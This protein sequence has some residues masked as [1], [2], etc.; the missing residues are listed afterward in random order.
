[1]ERICH[2]I[3]LGIGFLISLPHFEFSFFFCEAPGSW[4]LGAE[5]VQSVVCCWLLESVENRLITIVAINIIIILQSINC[6]RRF[7]R[8]HSFSAH[9]PPR[10]CHIN[11]YNRET[12]LRKG[13]GRQLKCCGILIVHV[14]G[15]C[16]VG[17]VY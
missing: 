15:F 1:M 6:C 2:G 3:A 16:G 7:R 5:N 11:K 9:F 13:A 4:K 10:V 12:R 17:N 14:N 8:F